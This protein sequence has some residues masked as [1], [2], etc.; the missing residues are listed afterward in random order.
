MNL[1]Q[2]NK[3]IIIELAAIDAMEK[4]GLYTGNQKLF[5]YAFRTGVQWAEAKTKYKAKLSYIKK[6]RGDVE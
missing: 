5:I 4:V 1:K 2:Q 6:M 3:N